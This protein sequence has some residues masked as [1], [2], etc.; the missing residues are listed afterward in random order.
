M[1]PLKSPEAI[2][3]ALQATLRTLEVPCP[4]YRNSCFPVCASRMR[5][6]PSSQASARRCLPVPSGDQAS[7]QIFVFT[8][9]CHCFAPCLPEETFQTPMLPCTSAAAKN[10]PPGDHARPV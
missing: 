4:V 8:L 9:I 10:W 7:D 3:E 1:E 5:T 2:E 6:L